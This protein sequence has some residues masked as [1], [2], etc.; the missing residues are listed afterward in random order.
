MPISNHAN[1]FWIVAAIAGLLVWTATAG[2]GDMRGFEGLVLGAI[3]TVLLGALLVW[4]NGGA[5]AGDTVDDTGQPSLSFDMFVPEGASPAWV[6]AV[7]AGLLVWIATAGIGDLGGVAGLL[8]G[9]ITT[10][11][12]GALMVWLSEGETQLTPLPT[13]TPNHVA[14]RNAAV[15]AEVPAA[16]MPDD[17]LKQIRGIGPKLEESLQAEGITRFD[18]IAAW[19]DSD[20]ERF[21]GLIGRTASRIR[22]EDWIGQARVLAGKK[23]R[24]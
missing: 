23:V 3:T 4:L 10:G 13:D 18:Q 12:L 17:D 7:I 20:V 22:S 9:V 16:P 19:T 6:A 24:R 11:L 8:L 2:V 14:T 5:G 21:A 15:R 1:S